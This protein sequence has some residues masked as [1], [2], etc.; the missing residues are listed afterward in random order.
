MSLGEYLPA[1]N[2]KQMVVDPSYLSTDDNQPFEREEKTNLAKQEERVS[3]AKKNADQ[4][5]QDTREISSYPVNLSSDMLLSPP[6]P[7]PLP[8][9]D[10]LN[11]VTKNNEM[12]GN[13]FGNFRQANPNPNPMVSSVV[14]AAKCFDAFQA[15][16]EKVLSNRAG[17]YRNFVSDLI[18]IIQPAVIKILKLLYFDFQLSIFAQSNKYELTNWGSQY[19]WTA[20]NETLQRWVKEKMT[21][22]YNLNATALQSQKLDEAR[23]LI[24]RL[25]LDELTGVKVK[26]KQQTSVSVQENLQTFL[27]QLILVI[28]ASL[29]NVLSA[30]NKLTHQFQEQLRQTSG[31]V[32]ENESFKNCSSVIDVR[33]SLMPLLPHLKT[34]ENLDIIYRLVPSPDQHLVVRSSGLAMLGPSVICNYIRVKTDKATCVAETCGI[35]TIFSEIA[36]LYHNQF[37]WIKR[38]YDTY[39]MDYL[40]NLGRI[41]Q[42]W[43]ER[44][45]WLNAWNGEFDKILADAIPGGGELSRTLSELSAL[46][47]ALVLTKFQDGLVNAVQNLTYGTDFMFLHTF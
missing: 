35:P 27:E 29:L 12:M 30:Y 13:E 8:L 2:V 11:L 10:T 14:P 36:A 23:T 32:R 5:N 26:A 20:L 1:H 39:N 7:L 37:V 18:S 9:P 19:I 31:Y 47:Q 44:N 16:F 25:G 45:C 40:H 42:Q 33:K 34:K 4:A 22:V 3:Q 24:Q 17:L 38:F 43:I 41:Q 28:K 46:D 15:Q 21:D 6:S